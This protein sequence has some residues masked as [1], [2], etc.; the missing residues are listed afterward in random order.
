MKMK[1]DLQVCLDALHMD[2]LFLLADTL[3][4]TVT[5]CIWKEEE[6]KDKQEFQVF[7]FAFTITAFAS[8]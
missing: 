6:A 4:R 3:V 2:L 7:H 1:T 5:P 8:F